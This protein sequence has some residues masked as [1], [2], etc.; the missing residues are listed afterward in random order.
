MEY[1]HKTNLRNVV[2]ALY[3]G[4]ILTFSFGF[5]HFMGESL[6]TGYQFA[7]IIL[8]FW[9]V[10]ITLYSLVR[11]RLIA[12]NI[13][14]FFTRILMYWA[15]LC[16]VLFLGLSLDFHEFFYFSLFTIIIFGVFNL[17]SR[18]FVVYAI[19]VIALQVLLDIHIVLYGTLEVPWIEILA[20]LLVF[21]LVM[22]IMATLCGAM[23]ALRGRLRLQNIELKKA[24]I[25][26]DIFVAKMS[27]ELRTPMIG[28]LGMLDLLEKTP[29]DSVQ[30]NY[31][32]TAKTSGN[33]L[34][35]LVNDILEYAKL[36][37]HGV[38]LV[39]LPFQF[40]EVVMSLVQAQYFQ[41]RKKG[42]EVIVYID[43]RMPETFIGD[44]IRVIQILNNLISNAIKYTVEGYVQVLVNAD[45]SEGSCLVRCLIQDTGIGISGEEQQAIFDQFKQ[46]SQN[47]DA[48]Y[49]GTGL[50]L[51]IA[52]Q[53]AHL[54]EADIE[55]ESE[56]GVGSQFTFTKRF[57]YVAEERNDERETFAEVSAIL[58]DPLEPRRQVLEDYLT[59]LG[60]G[61]ETFSDQEIR[62]IR[63]LVSNRTNKTIIILNA[64][65]NE[66]EDDRATAITLIESC[67]SL[68]P[69]IVLYSGRIACF[70]RPGVCFL[71]KPIDIEHLYHACSGL[72]MEPE[73]KNSVESS[74][75]SSTEVG[76]ATPQR[77]INNDLSV[78]VVEDNPVNQTVF[79]AM[80]QS[81]QV[82][83]DIVGSGESAIQALFE[84]PGLFGL[85]LM[86]C[87]L[88]GVNGYTAT[89]LIRGGSAGDAY[90]HIPVVVCSA[91]AHY[92][93]D[94]PDLGRLVS[95]YLPKP[96]NLSELQSVLEL[97]LPGKRT[98]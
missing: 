26:K 88:S 78:L 83:F 12:A 60:V 6:V 54:M 84:R 53:L 56:V 38:E 23:N 94:D 80:L 92:E 73:V 89:K 71:Q 42:L 55:V 57:D 77:T 1:G 16:C 30:K 75:H 61:V 91:G 76:V 46:G 18:D 3:G 31:V 21:S 4:A 27:H 5:A 32:K 96:F 51:T 22:V 37:H 97:Y 11:L 58:I 9:I 24:L 65:L 93:E 95:G 35:S 90:R 47:L 2:L 64:D 45:L 52:N 8:A 15:T 34:T 41:A 81:L 69:L 14:P 20:R 67:S 66:K 25:A 10:N 74:E 72:C 59:Y 85:I 70:N 48:H 98:A 29:L 87:E 82:P 43:P 44:E 49:G 40:K 36:K 68:A 39:S 79:R 19:C 50:G 63:K 7:M 86:D 17:S 28:V 13:T 33:I 62:D